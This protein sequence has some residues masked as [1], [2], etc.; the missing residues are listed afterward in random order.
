MSDR[1]MDSREGLRWPTESVY[2]SNGTWLEE[3]HRGR[4]SAAQAVHLC[5]HFSAFF[6][7]RAL[8]FVLPTLV[9]NMISLIQTQKT[10]GVLVPR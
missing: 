4:E 5:V 3:G 1:E 7:P 2:I 6:G 10:F 8:T 9:L